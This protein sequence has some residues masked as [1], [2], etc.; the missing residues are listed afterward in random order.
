[1]SSMDFTLQDEYLLG[2][3]EHDLGTSPKA[4]F[5]YL[6][7]GQHCIKG[8]FWVRA[9]GTRFLIVGVSDISLKESCI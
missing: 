4:A 5:S 8:Y 9:K 1:M 3:T 7:L 6:L 2:E